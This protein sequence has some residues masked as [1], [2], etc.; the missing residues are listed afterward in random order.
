[1]S[2]RQNLEYALKDKKDTK[3]SVASLR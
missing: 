3:I 1:M 2:V